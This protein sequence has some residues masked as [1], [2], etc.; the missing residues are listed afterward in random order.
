MRAKI[1]EFINKVIYNYQYKEAISDNVLVRSINMRVKKI[2]SAALTCAIGMATVCPSLISAAESEKYIL[3]DW[4]P[5]GNCYWNSTDPQ[6]YDQLITSEN[7]P[8]ANNLGQFVSSKRMFTRDDIPIGSYIEIDQGY[9]YRPESWSADIGKNET[10]NRPGN[11]KES[12]VY[13]D[14]DWWGDSVYKAFN[15]SAVDSSQIGNKVDEIRDVF[16][17]Y[18]P[19]E[20]ESGGDED[21]DPT[22]PETTQIPDELDTIPYD[23]ENDKD[24]TL[25]ILAIG[26]SFSEDA[27]EYLYNIATHSGF[28][29]N[30]VVLANLFIGGGTLEQHFANSQNG[31]SYTLQKRDR[32]NSIVTFSRTLQSAVRD[33]DWDIITL[34]Q[35][36][37]SSGMAETYEPYLSD[38]IDIIEEN[39]TNP[40]MKL[41]WHMTWAY[42]QDTTHNEFYKYDNDQLTMYNAVVG[43]V[44]EKVLP[45]NK[46]D[47]IIPS[48][49]AVQNMR[50]SFAGDILTRDG[51]HMGY[52]LGRYII[53]LTWFKSITGADMDDVGWEP[54]SIGNFK[55]VSSSPFDWVY[56]G[57]EEMKAAKESVNNAVS[58]KFEVTQSAYSEYTGDYPYIISNPVISGT[59]CEVV[60]TRIG[61][62]DSPV[63]LVLAA[64]DNNGELISIKTEEKT[65]EK[66]SGVKIDLS[67]NFSKGCRL[68][69]FVFESMQSAKPL[70][71]SAE[72]TL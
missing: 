2:I 1:L 56:I 68:K 49:T 46:F 11:I 28:E 18:V 4:E 12:V 13:V 59:K 40:D 9:Q 19:D 61:N 35:A 63:T 17:V 70:A 38:L 72:K 48:G 45:L 47:F 60:F 67:G 44:K 62:D 29:K 10:Q 57:D 64:Y 15:I 32:S 51:Y 41:G 33:E 54:M 37:G 3:L 31:T 36:S 53:G 71:V 6:L 39:A 27:M 69:A 7:K 21:T 24:G 14:E 20:G 23:P 55:T 50:T 30:E 8:G 16:R 66:G 43:A 65:P 42:Q 34:Q 25:K 22:E 58:N 52:V 5:Q 26:N